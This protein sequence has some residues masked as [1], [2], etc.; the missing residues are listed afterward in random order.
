MAT[1][2]RVLTGVAAALAGGFMGGAMT[3]AAAQAVHEGHAG[4]P[5]YSVVE[6]EGFNLQVTDN[7]TNRLFFYA[8]DKDQPVGSDLKLRG[9]IDLN[10]VGH[11][12]IQPT[13]GAAKPNM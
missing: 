9:S 11:D 12:A 5:H 13:R 8:A 3:A 7:T 4:V 1:R 2:G 6:S 10:Q